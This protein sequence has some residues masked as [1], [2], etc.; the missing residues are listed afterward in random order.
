MGGRCYRSGVVTVG[1][2][3]GSGDTSRLGGVRDGVGR[4]TMGGNEVPVAVARS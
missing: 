4:E 3:W 2:G 1:G